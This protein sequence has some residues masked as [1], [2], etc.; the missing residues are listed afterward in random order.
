MENLLRDQQSIVAR[1]AEFAEEL[2]ERPAVA[3]VRCDRCA[4]E[5]DASAFEGHVEEQH[6][7]GGVRQLPARPWPRLLLQVA[8]ACPRI[9]ELLRDGDAARALE[10]MQTAGINEGHQLGAREDLFAVD[11]LFGAADAVTQSAARLDGGVRVLA[12]V[13]QYPGG[14]V[15]LPGEGGKKEAVT[16]QV[17]SG[18]EALEEALRGA[19]SSDQLRRSSLGLVLLALEA[20]ANDHAAAGQKKLKNRTSLL[21]SAMYALLIIESGGALNVLGA[22]FSLPNSERAK[23]L[24]EFMG[25]LEFVPQVG[26]AGH[27]RPRKYSFRRFLQMLGKNK[28]SFAE[29]QEQERGAVLAAAAAPAGGE[30]PASARRIGAGPTSPNPYAVGA[31]A[32]PCY[33]PSPPLPPFGMREADATLARRLGEMFEVFVRGALGMLAANEEAVGTASEAAA[34]VAAV[35]TALKEEAI[36]DKGEVVKWAEAQEFLP[37]LV[38]SYYVLMRAMLSD[39]WRVTGSSGIRDYLDEAGVW[40]NVDGAVALRSDAGALWLWDYRRVHFRRAA[41]IE[42]D[43]DFM[44]EKRGLCARRWA[45][46][47]NSASWRLAPAT[48]PRGFL[49]S[50]IHDDHVVQDLLS[51]AAI[52]AIRDGGA[53]P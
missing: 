36:L 1:L 16:K 27:R 23:S 28:A 24:E 32:T 45:A 4:A 13:L 50:Y 46:C 37:L 39:G 21:L 30:P 31:A 29:R 34:G 52:E 47:T 35:V 5:L 22:N 38:S 10:T 2:E 7:L 33:L 41:A 18:K 53:A 20:A 8:A 9:R 11:T 6:L 19:I 25:P 15:E 14:T 17:P 40:R 12:V 49:V 3:R 44:A 51:A 43:E 26:E 42:G 48:R